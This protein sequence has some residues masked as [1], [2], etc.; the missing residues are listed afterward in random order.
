MSELLDALRNAGNDVDDALARFMG[1]EG[2]YVRFLGK[3]Q[4]DDSFDKLG[5]A[6]VAGDVKE[7][8]AASHTLKGVLGNL[9]LTRL[10]D[11][12][13]PIVETARGGNLPAAADV[14]AFKAAY[15]ETLAL[16]NG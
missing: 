5:A 15:V 13:T 7:T 2:M 11:L 10:V 9:G 12:N 6:F 1:N 14:D 16:I 8:F 3:L 4:S